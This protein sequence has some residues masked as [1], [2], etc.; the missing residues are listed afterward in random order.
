MEMSWTI[1]AC[2]ISK[3]L[4]STGHL[5][6][7]PQTGERAA[8][9]KGHSRHLQSAFYSFSIK[10]ILFYCVLKIPAPDFSL[11]L[12]WQ[13]DASIALPQ[14]PSLGFDRW[15]EVGVGLLWCGKHVSWT[16]LLNWDPEKELPTFFLPCSGT[17]RSSTHPS[18]GHK[19][20]CSR[21]CARYWCIARRRW[22]E[23]CSQGNTGCTWKGCWVVLL[24]GEVKGAA[25][26]HFTT[27]P[28]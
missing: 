4:Q 10:I 2:Y 6:L 9:P 22:C 11:S 18:D 21:A 7:P 25:S 19:P 17:C 15:M 8:L 26:V 20:Q 23:F 3:T 16:F 28:H 24:L 1:S 27:K 14:K 13:K 5:W 12:C